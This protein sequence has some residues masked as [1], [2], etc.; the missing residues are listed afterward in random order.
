MK[1][2]AILVLGLV[3]AFGTM[4]GC[5]ST[6]EGQG[7]QA[8]EQMPEVDYSKWKLYIQLGVKISAN[9]LL[10]EGSVTAKELELVATAIETARDQ[11]VIPGAT[12]II[13]PA[14]DKIG[15]TN[16]EV[17]LVLMVAE[18]ELLSRGA[19]NWI[20]PTTGVVDLSPR[21]KDILTV[22]AS[23]LR[24]AT[25]VTEEEHQQNAQLQDQFGYRFVKLSQ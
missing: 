8:L 11:T 21:T 2:L 15:F 22:V 1:K 25:K 17:E 13:K 3:C 18:Q 6:G 9:R 10:R 14:L 24:A 23:S 19:L 16:D 20:N 12:G 7:I 5:S 4:Q